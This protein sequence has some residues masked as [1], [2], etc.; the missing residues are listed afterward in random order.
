MNAVECLPVGS[1]VI[2]IEG[3]FSARVTAVV[4]RQNE[5]AYECAWWDG[6]N[7]VCLILEDWELVPE[8]TDIERLRVNAV[9]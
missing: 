5:V 1:N 2:V 9:L 4:I 7:R 6:R 8:T 3:G